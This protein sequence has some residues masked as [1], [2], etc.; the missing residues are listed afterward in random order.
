[1][2]DQVAPTVSYAASDELDLIRSIARQ[3][4]TDRLDLEVVRDLMMSEDGFERGLWKEIAGLGWTGLIIDE[5]HGG[6]GLGFVELSVILEEIGRVVTPGPFFASSVLATAAIQQSATEEQKAD[7]LPALASGETIASLGLFEE[8]RGW[9]LS[10]VE[11]AARR[12]SDSWVID[13]MKRH[14]L[15]GHLADQIVVAAR[16]D[17]GVGL[18]VVDAA[19]SGLTVRQTPVLDPTRRQ[20]EVA[21]DSVRVDDAALLGDARA[22]AA[23]VRTLALGT[24]ALA[25]EQVGGAQRCLEMSVEHAKTRYQFGRAIGSY[26]AIKHR[27]AQMLLKV[28]HAKSAAYHAARVTEDPEELGIAAPLAGSVC[29]EA[30]LWAAGETI[31]IHGGIGFTWEHD[32][33]LHLKRARSSALLLGDPRHH[34]GLL[35]DALGF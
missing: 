35:G 30:Y 8:P 29:S 34:R 19:V 24:V 22:D 4:L 7:L 13:G 26:Q 31:Q 12:D 10:H 14:V 18:F 1:V 32:A 9:D 21:L 17:G 28:E 27:C 15:D 33:H 5:E 3:F 11:C 23:I 20:A 6:A 16:T 25:A 2:A